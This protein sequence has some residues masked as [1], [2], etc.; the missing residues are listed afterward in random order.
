MLGYRDSAVEELETMTGQEA[1]APV[2]RTGLAALRDH[3]PGIAILAVTEVWERMSY[4]GM[5]ALLVFYMTKQLMLSQPHASM[6][7]GLYTAAVWFAPLPGGFLAD[8]YLGQHRSV[9]VGGTLMALGHFLMA[10]EPL[11][12]PALAAIAAGNGLFKPNISTQVGDLYAA[13]DPRR[14]RGYS[15][16]YVGVNLGAFIAPLVCGTVGELYGWHWGFGLAGI[17]MLFGLLTYSAGRRWLPPD[18]PLRRPAAIA[19]AQ[20]EQ[21]DRA[22]VMAL[23]AI[24]LSAAFFWMIYEQQG[25]TI[26]LWADAAIDRR[27]DLGP[28][29]GVIPATWFQSLNGLFIFAL[30]PLLVALW[31]RQ[32]ARRQEPSSTMKTVIGALIAAGTYGVLAVLTLVLGPKSSISWLWLVAYFVAMTLAELYLSPTCL[33]LFNKAAPKRLAST[34]V[35]VWYLSLFLGSYFA[36]WAGSFWSQTSRP[37]FFAAMAVFGL[38]SAAALWL[39]SRTFASALGSKTA[40]GAGRD[41]ALAPFSAPSSVASSDP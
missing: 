36:G 15:I 4:Y 13:D 23:I 18:R 32:A 40:P 1:A 27:V 22:K 21:T 2:L 19:A 39:T 37:L 11:F 41:S 17:G 30:T 34:F 38:L 5:R 31:G 28:V 24:S 33:S 6:V 12:Y 35:G 7:Y 14:D 25:N 16:Y 3:P 9:L 8:R 10:F 26:A 20:A 29:H